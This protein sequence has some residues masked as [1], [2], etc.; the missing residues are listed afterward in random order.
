MGFGDILFQKHAIFFRVSRKGR[1]GGGG[2]GS[3]NLVFYGI[4]LC[5][6][7]VRVLPNV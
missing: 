7:V 3:L 6:V 1:G 4:G 5:S 2:G